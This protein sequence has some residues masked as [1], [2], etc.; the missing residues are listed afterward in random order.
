MAWSSIFGKLLDDVIIE[1]EKKEIEIE[2]GI[3]VGNRTK[4]TYAKFQLARCRIR[5]EIEFELQFLY[6]LFDI[7]CRFDRVVG[8]LILEATHQSRL[9]VAPPPRQGRCL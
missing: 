9:R 8:K 4:Y 1:K 7:I 2:N 6:I 5:A 3:F